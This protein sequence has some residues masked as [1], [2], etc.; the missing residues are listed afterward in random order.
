M[1]G[2]PAPRLANPVFP[3]A[4]SLV[5]GAK[6]AVELL[7]QE[8]RSFSGEWKTVTNGGHKFVMTLKLNRSVVRA[9]INPSTAC[10]RGP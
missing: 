9:A 6:A 1:S 4:D 10:S 2:I 3:D 8:M 7:L 5:A